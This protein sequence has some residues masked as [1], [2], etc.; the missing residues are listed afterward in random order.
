MGNVTASA[1]PA[2][3]HDPNARRVA[4]WVGVIGAGAALIG[5]VI[6]GI[7]SVV[8]ANSAYENQAAQ[9]ATQ[10]HQ[11]KLVESRSQRLSAYKAWLQNEEPVLGA[12]SNRNYCL[13]K[14]NGNLNVCY[15]PLKNSMDKL[16]AL[17][18]TVIDVEIFGSDESVQLARRYEELALKWL[19]SAGDPNGEEVVSLRNE[20]FSIREKFI[21]TS[22]SEI[23]AVPRAGC[24]P[25]SR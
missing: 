16:R 4:L 23:S 8:V 2:A 11:T 17:G 20:L 24:S 3:D 13:W 15:D 5:S 22:C 6:G 10:F 7:T 14:N 25:G 19:H 9:Q 1:S 18:G 21:T 12:V